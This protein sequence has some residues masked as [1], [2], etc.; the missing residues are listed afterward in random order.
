M[1]S[2][3]P[4]GQASNLIHIQGPDEMLSKTEA[5]WSHPLL[6]LRLTQAPWYL[7]ERSL[8]PDLSPVFV[9]TELQTPLIIWLWW[10]AKLKLMGPAER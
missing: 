2:P 7:P 5:G 10:P 4:E 6:F 3:S 9:A 1:R 8:Y